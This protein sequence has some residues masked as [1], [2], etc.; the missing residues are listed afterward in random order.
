MCKNGYG[1]VIKLRT[2][3][4]IYPVFLL[5]ENNLTIKT[6]RINVL[7]Y[8]ENRVSLMVSPDRAY[9][10]DPSIDGVTPTVIPLTM[11]E[12]KYG[13]NSNAFKSGTLFFEKSQEA[14]VYEALNIPNWKDILKN[15]D[16][17]DI[18]LHPTYDG[19]SKIIAIEDGT[20][21]ERV[22]GVYHKL[23]SEG[24]NDISVRVEQIIR[25]RYKELINGHVKTSIQLT[26][27]DFND[28]AANNVEIE[29]LKE[30]NKSLQEQISQLKGL[31]ESMAASE[32]TGSVDVENIKGNT[33][34]TK[35]IITSGKKRGRPP[36]NK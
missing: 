32:N 20:M 27:K 4:G 29:A 9:S 26:K 14:D 1:L 23:L 8:N 28:N 31:I 10:F 16:I 12:V 18:I 19:L 11:D 15:E 17:C 21:F 30:Q 24:T 35:N 2:G 25:T 7:N 5:E 22:R 3:A 34:V 13:N 6:E 36:K 33:T